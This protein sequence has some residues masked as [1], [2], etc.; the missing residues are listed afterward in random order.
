M[1]DGFDIPGLA[2]ILSL[3]AE[4]KDG[5][6]AFARHGHA[7]ALPERIVELMDAGTPLGRHLAYGVLFGVRLAIDRRACDFDVANER[8]EQPA[9]V[10]HHHE[11]PSLY[12]ERLP[13][14]VP[15]LAVA[16]FEALTGQ[17]PVATDW[18][19]DGLRFVYILETGKFLHVLADSDVAHME[20]ERDKILRD[21]RHALFY[22]SYKLKPRDEERT[23]AGRVRIFRT[24]E[25]VTAGRVMLL[26]D[27]DYD[28]AREHGCFSMPSRDTMI[29]GRPSA[30]N[31]SAEI[32][33]RVCEVTADFLASE[34]FPLCSH[35]H[36]MDTGGVRAG[37][38]VGEDEL[39]T[40]GDDV[41]PPDDLIIENTR[42]E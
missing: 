11:I 19:I 38:Y 42:T 15:A 20:M 28:A 7:V 29:I 39:P 9:Q 30:E 27:F 25:G 18:I 36:R 6:V 24:A 34:A 33:E 2:S 40:F 10:F 4:E 41:L 16:W 35:V 22:D 13:R 14:L 21:A 37:E 23:D 32:F 3:K 5:A 17:E 26:P 1:N 31:T 8:P 12:G